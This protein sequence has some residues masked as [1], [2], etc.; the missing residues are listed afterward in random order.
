[1]R[2][3]TSAWMASVTSHTLTFIPAVTLPSDIQKA[4]N[5]RAARSPRTTT[6]SVPLARPEYSMPTSYWSEKK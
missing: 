3:R 5:S 2:E 6:S 4:M 1:M